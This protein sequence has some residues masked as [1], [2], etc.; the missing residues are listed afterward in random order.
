ML[1]RLLGLPK[2]TDQPSRQDEAR[3]FGVRMRAARTQ[4]RRS[5]SVLARACSV[6]TQ[7]LSEIER[8]RRVP[9]NEDRLR[10]ARVLSIE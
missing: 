8:G 10:I 2:G 7:Y 5:L 9:A 4:Q 6:N 1:R 3:A